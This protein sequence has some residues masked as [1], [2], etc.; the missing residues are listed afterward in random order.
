MKRLQSHKQPFI[1][2]TVLTWLIFHSGVAVAAEASRAPQQPTGLLI[3]QQGTRNSQ[4]YLTGAQYNGANALGFFWPQL[5]S[6][7]QS[8]AVWVDAGLLATPSIGVGYRQLFQQKQ[9]NQL[10]FW[11][12]YLYLESPNWFVNP[13]IMSIYKTYFEPAQH[14]EPN[15]D[16]PAQHQEPNTKSG[17]VLLDTLGY[18][19][20][21]I[22]TEI[23]TPRVN[24]TLNAYGFLN[25]KELMPLN[26]NISK[27]RPGFSARLSYGNLIKSFA[28]ISYNYV[29]VPNDHSKQ[30]K[31][32]WLTSVAAGAR[33]NLTETLS[34]EFKVLKDFGKQQQSPIHIGVHHCSAATRRSKA[35]PAGYSALPERHILHYQ[36]A[37]IWPEFV[38]KETIK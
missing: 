33:Y 31:E 27:E 28:A 21:N 3:H 5:F 11:G 10:C 7:L 13:Y 26:M 20:L 12:A 29:S 14:Q 30:T 17:S 36:N 1:V 2:C 25:K 35:L 15:T 8:K 19:R 4:F 38:K 23:G 9:F 32:Q 34:A 16:E 6:G 24:I 37:K 22:G 18:T